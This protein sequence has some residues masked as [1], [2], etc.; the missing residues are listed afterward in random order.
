MYKRQIKYSDEQDD[1]I[2]AD[3]IYEAKIEELQLAIMKEPISL[4]QKITL[5]HKKAAEFY[6]NGD[7]NNALEFLKLAMTIDN[8]NNITLKN[9]GFLL[10]KIG[11]EEEAKAYFK[12]IEEVDLMIIDTV[13]YTHL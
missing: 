6:K 12:K 1:K 11:K 5:C 4:I 8:T 3:N 7:F 10:V 13:S 9:M 2:I